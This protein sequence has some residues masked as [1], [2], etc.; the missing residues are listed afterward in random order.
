MTRSGPD[1]F[2][3]GSATDTAASSRPPRPG[4]PRNSAATKQALL[5]AAR[6]LFAT[7][8]FDAT[9]VRAIA[10]RAGVNQALLFRHFGNK[11]GLFAAA[12]SG[13]AMA[14]LEDGTDSD[15]LHRTLQALLCDGQGGTELL[16]AVLR[17]TGNRDAGLALREELESRWADAFGRLVNTSDAA[18]ARLRAELLLG[19]LLGIGLLRTVITTKPMTDADPDT[20]ID[21]VTRA[22][23]ALLDHP[24][25][26]REPG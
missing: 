24:G 17:S 25:P 26:P 1:A 3:N 15:L 10:E 4:R 22:A 12:M 20:I 21:H 9:T 7:V 8:G 23:S 5:G 19:W 2:E 13:D 6:E 16:F 14:V 18:D 11:E